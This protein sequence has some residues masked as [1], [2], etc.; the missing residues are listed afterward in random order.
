[1][2]IDRQGKLYGLTLRCVR[3]SKTLMRAARAKEP[4]YIV[5]ND[6]SSKRETILYRYYH[7]FEI[8]E[9]FRDLKHIFSATSTFIQRVQ[10][11]QAILLFQALGI[12]CLWHLEQRS[13][14]M[15]VHSKKTVSWV[16][17][18]FECV[19]HARLLPVLSFDSS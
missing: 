1:M 8:E 7:R 19:L 3:S 14:A 18:Q 17:K 16:K 13:E 4:W 5:T 15:K 9:T 12:W 10:T 11:L 2:T 6:M